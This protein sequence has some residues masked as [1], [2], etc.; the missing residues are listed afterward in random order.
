MIE[1]K[2]GYSAFVRRTT[3]FFRIYGNNRHY[4]VINQTNRGTITDIFQILQC[5]CCQIG[6]GLDHIIVMRYAGKNTFSAVCQKERRMNNEIEPCNL[7][8]REETK[9]WFAR[10]FQVSIRVHKETNRIT[11]LAVIK[12]W[13]QPKIL[14]IQVIT[15][16]LCQTNMLGNCLIISNSFFNFLSVQANSWTKGEFYFLQP[17]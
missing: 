9:G 10:R 11:P 1:R 14:I 4:I 16:I 8:R 3:K 6:K 13:E 17:G 7:F 15:C 2:K 5:V 12:S